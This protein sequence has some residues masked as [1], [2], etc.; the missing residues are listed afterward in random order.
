LEHLNSAAHD[1]NLKSAAD[2]RYLNSS[3]YDGHLNSAAH[4]RRPAMTR[5]QHASCVFAIVLCIACRADSGDGDSAIPAS[6]ADSVIPVPGATAS[7]SADSNLGS[8]PFDP[9][10][11]ASWR[12]SPRGYGP[13]VAGLTVAAADSIVP[14]TI[15]LPPGAEP[16][17]DFA[18]WSDAPDGVLIMVENGVIARIDVTERGVV[19][20]EG[21][22]VGDSP[23]RIDS[24][25]G[26]RVRISPHK[27]VDGSHYRIIMSGL[28]G[29]TVSRIVFETDSTR[30]T[31]FRS[32]RFPAVEYVES[33]H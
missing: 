32:G 8:P 2:D 1:G 11:I 21:I 4:D 5:I 33:C 29:D 19:T 3:A 17:C 30:V 13:L 27:Y 18:R 28:P 25:Y 23:A 22:G 24:V 6:A 14:G 16:A 31:R 7:V 20:G 15:V 12:I 10:N 26:P 9:N